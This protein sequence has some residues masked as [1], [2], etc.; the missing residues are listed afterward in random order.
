[1][2]PVVD[3][4]HREALTRAG[5]T[6]IRRLFNAEYL[7]DFGPWDPAQPY[8]YA[9]HDVHVIACAA[10]GVVVGHA[11]WGRREI[12]VGGASVVIAGV[13]GVLVSAS[14]RGLRLGERL[15]TALAHSM[16]EAGGIDFG[17]LGCREDVVPFYEACGWQRIA[18]AERSVARDGT[19]VEDLPGQPL[20]ILP[21][22]S[23]RGAWPPGLVDLRGRAW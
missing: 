19:P 17:Y 13:G 14:A 9:P 15:M 7:A 21:V 18:A 20:L 2:D 10:D 23:V 5:L 1:M 8:G 22:E 11:G 3:V 4:V 16:A 6:R 12:S